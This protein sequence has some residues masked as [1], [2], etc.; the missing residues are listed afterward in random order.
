MMSTLLPA[1]LAPLQ[2]AHTRATIQDHIKRS[3]VNVVN[4]E[5]IV[6]S[7]GARV[8]FARRDKDRCGPRSLTAYSR[9]VLSGVQD[10][11]SRIYQ[12]SVIV[13][14][15][16]IATTAVRTQAPDRIA[17][18]YAV[19]SFV[20]RLTY[21]THGGNATNDYTNSFRATGHVRVNDQVVDVIMKILS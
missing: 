14:L 9:F 6:S 17:R 21:Q 15:F 11:G 2:D 1:N 8:T 5:L 16:E 4:G 7:P 10:D 20:T 18:K 13:A 3:V 19:T 12:R